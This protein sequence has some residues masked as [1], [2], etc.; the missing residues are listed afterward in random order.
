MIF[1]CR[2][3]CS[4]AYCLSHVVSIYIIWKLEEKHKDMCQEKIEQNKVSRDQVKARNAR[5][6]A[7]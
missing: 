6:L 4:Y 2:I 3:L 5:F 7:Y 1:F